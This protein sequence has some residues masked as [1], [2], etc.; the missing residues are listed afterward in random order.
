M[1]LVNERI[2]GLISSLIEKSVEK[3]VRFWPTN[4]FQGVALQDCGANLPR[5]NML[6]EIEI[7]KMRIDQESI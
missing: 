2:G 3:K 7:W 5:Q 1:S 4:L 6:Q